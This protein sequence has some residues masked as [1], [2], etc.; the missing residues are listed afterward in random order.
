MVGRDFA[1]DVG[2]V[3]EGAEEIDR[4]NHRFTRRHTHHGGIVRVFEANQHVVPVNGVQI[5]QSA[6][7]HRRADFRAAAA[8]T[9]G[10]GGDR[11][12]GFFLAEFDG[13]LHGR[14]GGFCRCVHFG[15]L[16]ELGHEA[17][18]D[19][20]FPLPDPVTCK[21]K[22][23]ARGDGVFVAGADERQPASLRS[24]GL[25]GRARDSSAQVFCERRAL[26]YSKHAGLFQLVIHHAGDVACRENMWVVHGL[27][28]V[29]HI[30]KAVIIQGEAG[31]A[32]PGRTARAGDPNDLIGLQ[33]LPV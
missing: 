14:G 26:A 12:Q 16:A 18:V 11:L 23:A 33:T 1:E 17:P 3:N 32:Q 5:A 19:P 21:A 31:F 20:V 10:D 15:K 2:V 29:Q 7:Q 4:V 6:L 8:T 25:H 22:P 30:E 27:Q 13:A 24:V 9:H 28:G